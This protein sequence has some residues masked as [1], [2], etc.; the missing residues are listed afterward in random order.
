[1]EYADPKKV[2]EKLDSVGCGFCL[3][4]WTQVCPFRFR[5]NPVVYHVRAPTIPEEVK[6]NPN[7]LH[8]TRFKK[9]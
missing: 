8:N 2:K 3:A 6:K 4:K 1:M 9:R 5:F 7:V